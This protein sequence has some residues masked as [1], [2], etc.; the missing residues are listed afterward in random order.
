MAQGKFHVGIG[1][2][3]LYPYVS[4]VIFNRVCCCSYTMA[5]KDVGWYVLDVVRPLVSADLLLMELPSSRSCACRRERCRIPAD[6][7]QSFWMSLFLC[8]FLYVPHIIRQH[9]VPATRE[10]QVDLFKTGRRGNRLIESEALFQR[11]FLQLTGS[12]KKTQLQDHNCSMMQ[13]CNNA[14]FHLLTQC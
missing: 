11:L 4:L 1:N 8:V 6:C 5:G 9:D 12:V 13:Y 14:F 2:I 7:R 10:G 3:T